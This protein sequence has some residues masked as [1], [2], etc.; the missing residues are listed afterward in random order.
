MI[1]R[2][3]FQMSALASLPLSST[4]IAGAALA[5][6]TRPTRIVVGFPAGGG[7]DVA[8]RALASRIQSAYPA[9]LSAREVEVLRLLAAGSTNGEIAERLFLGARTVETHIRAIYHKLGHTSRT[10]ATRFAI[11]HHLT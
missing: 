1:T 9:G 7:S 11:E 4:L 3:T 6:P 10:A 8:A 5:Q 2:R